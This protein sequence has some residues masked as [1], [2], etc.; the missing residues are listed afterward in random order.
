MK[1][2]TFQFELEEGSDEFWEADPKP[3][4]VI[5]MVRCE[6]GNTN[7]WIDNLKI[8]KIIDET[9]YETPPEDG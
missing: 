2:Y 3:L 7:L 8:I 6:L 5:G 4:D 9:E 1:K